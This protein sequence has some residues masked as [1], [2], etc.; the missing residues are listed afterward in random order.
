MNNRSMSPVD[1]LSAASA[2]RP[3]RNDKIAS[4][5]GAASAPKEVTLGQNDLYPHQTCLDRILDQFGAVVDPQLL[6][7]LV[8]VKFN[9][10]G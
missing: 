6:H 8:L 3:P 2:F 1:H 10:S 9:R 7:D 4:S 5:R